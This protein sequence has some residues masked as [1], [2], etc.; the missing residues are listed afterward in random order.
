MNVGLIAKAGICD[1]RRRL[2]RERRGISARPLLSS[3]A[4]GLSVLSLGLPVF[5]LGNLDRGLEFSDTGFY[6]LN[7]RQFDQID[8]STTLFGTVWRL[9]PLPDDIFWNRLALLLL[10]GA[11]AIFA[12]DR[13]RN[14]IWP[15]AGTDWIDRVP[16]WCFVI[17]AVSIQYFYWTPDPSYN[18]ITLA[19]SLSL[20]GLSFAIIESFRSARRP[21][22]STLALAG[23][24][25]FLLAL[26]RAPSAAVTGLACG[27]LAVLLARPGLK[28]LLRA[29][30]WGIAG[31]A[32]AAIALTI[33]VEPIWVSLARM[34]AGLD[35][36]F[37]TGL[38]HQELISRLGDDLGTLI[39]T[40]S[41]SIIGL[42]ICLALT[43]PLLQNQRAVSLRWAAGLMALVILAGQGG[44]L[45][46]QSFNSEPP[47]T[48]TKLGDLVYVVGAS[49]LLATLIRF[50]C[51]VYSGRDRAAVPMFGISICL[52][53]VWFGQV[54]LS[55]N[56][57]YSFAALFAVYP[58]LGLVLLCLDQGKLR[59]EP[60]ALFCFA[61]LF[62]SCGA[63]TWHISRQPYR[64]P[65]PLAQQS[66][67][68]RLRDGRSRILVD[69]PTRDLLE[70]LQD[71]AVLMGPA[72]NRPVL[73]DL[74]GRLPLVNYCL[75]APVPSRAWLLSGYPGSQALFMQAIDS[76]GE[77]ELERAWLLDAPD[78]AGRHDPS[79]LTS[80]GFKIDRDYIEVFRGPSAY[81]GSDIILLA[82]RSDCKAGRGECAKSTG[83]GVQ[84]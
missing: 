49:A 6:L 83:S 62:I 67:P 81:L 39:Q 80:R 28:P 69:I 55:T 84:R 51:S 12:I 33:L 25:L 45:V 54:V 73:I 56:D 82:P 2:R 53:L 63:T 52:V 29:L 11:A 75:D 8:A 72:G 41:L 5:V 31:S 14:L 47:I 50:G 27:L 16:V 36:G 4:I 59:G 1:F 77:E 58:L 19:L 15:D 44:D 66:E 21:P 70:G 7:L 64:L 74:T 18:A 30:A 60:V 65:T 13:A 32:I 57:L 46:R 35:I 76:L 37:D 17:G 68:V 3:V 38:S 79:H 42:S 71:A 24:L 20:L 23:A 61:V 40:H 26:T 10:L 34:R 43:G 9:L 22:A 78:F 48:L